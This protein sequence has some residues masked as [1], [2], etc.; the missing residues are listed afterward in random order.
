MFT[1]LNS[2]ILSSIESKNV[3]WSSEESAVG[4]YRFAITY[5]LPPTMISRNRNHPSLSSIT[6][7]TECSRSRPINVITPLELEVPWRKYAGP[8]HS[9]RQIFSLSSVLWLSWIRHIWGFSLLTLSKTLLLLRPAIRP[10][11]LTDIIL[12]LPIVWTTIRVAQPRSPNRHQRAEERG[13]EEVTQAKWT[14]G[15]LV[16]PRADVLL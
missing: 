12:R 15:H 4:A 11:A 6:Q 7:P 2:K 3:R 16:R 5:V 1:G 14:W 10:F 9:L 13:G 8:P